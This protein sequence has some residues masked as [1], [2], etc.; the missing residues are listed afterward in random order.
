M[1]LWN[2]I[3][4]MWMRSQ[5]RGKLLNIHVRIDTNKCM[6]LSS[7]DLRIKLC[8]LEEMGFSED[9]TLSLPELTCPHFQAWMFCVLK[10]KILCIL[11]Y[12]R[13][14]LTPQSDVGC[15]LTRNVWKIRHRFISVLAF[16]FTLNHEYFCS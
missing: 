4:V 15:I 13:C 6:L 10:M 12:P 16:R 9:K 1:T 5:C 2:R 14:L 3:I 11:H 8:A 7:W